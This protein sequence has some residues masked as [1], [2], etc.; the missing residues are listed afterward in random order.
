MKIIV[1]APLLDVLV[2]EISSL[3]ATWTILDRYVQILDT[4]SKNKP[5]CIIIFELTI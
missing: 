4:Q 3:R 5:R 1:G 2:E